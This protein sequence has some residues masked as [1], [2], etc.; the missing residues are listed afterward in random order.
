MKTEEYLSW[1]E[2]FPV[3]KQ[4]PKEPTKTTTLRIPVSLWKRIQHQAIEENKGIA[5]LI[6][7]AV[8]EHLKK[9]ESR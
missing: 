7:F 8:T 3:K 9:G 2:V 6:L 5:E 1:Q 4:K